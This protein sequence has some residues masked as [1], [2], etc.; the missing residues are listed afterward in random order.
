MKLSRVGELALR[1]LPERRHGPG[2]EQVFD[3]QDAQP[4]LH[5]AKKIFRIFN[6]LMSYAS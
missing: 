6:D 4:P 5:E 1:E 3:G 2:V